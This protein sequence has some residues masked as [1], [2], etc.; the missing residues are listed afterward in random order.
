[1]TRRGPTLIKTDRHCNG[2]RSEEAERKNAA[3]PVGGGN[4]QQ[5]GRGELYPSSDVDVLI[6]LPSEPDAATQERLEKFIGTL[7]DVGLEIGHS[8]RTLESCVENARSD[9]TV[10]TSLLEARLLA[11]PPYAVPE[12]VVLAA[13]GGRAWSN[14]FPLPGA[15]TPF[16]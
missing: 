4:E 16:R 10:E 14:P 7:W 5:Y 11:L 12:C 15:Q 6:L 3:P 9:I 2:E 8:V 13:D 1:M